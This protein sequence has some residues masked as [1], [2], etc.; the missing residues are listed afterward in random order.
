[1]CGKCQAPVSGWVMGCQGPEMVPAFHGRVASLSPSR[2][3]QMC[4]APAALVPAG[5]DVL[6]LDKGLCG[7]IQLVDDRVDD[8]GV[9]LHLHLHIIALTVGD[10]KEQTL[11]NVE[12]LPVC[13]T[14]CLNE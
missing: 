9:V 2:S 1:M 7:D 8:V 4:P 13:S 6:E 11:P 3:P 14:E 12:D 5:G 10:S